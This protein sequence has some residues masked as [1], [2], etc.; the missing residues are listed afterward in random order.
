MEQTW[1][2]LLT[3]LAN[4]FRNCACWSGPKVGLFWVLRREH[5]G[6]AACGG[7]ALGV[8]YTCS[9]AAAIWVA[10]GG[11][12]PAQRLGHA[13][14]PRPSRGLAGMHD[15]RAAFRGARRAYSVL[16]S[17]RAV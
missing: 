2:W 5:P 9:V 16:G 8:V 10:P 13:S 11:F 7:L 1:S 14:S 12:A 4:T 15:R 17:L 3:L 6:E